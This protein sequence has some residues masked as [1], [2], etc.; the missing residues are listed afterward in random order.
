MSTVTVVG[1]PGSRRVVGFAGAA[2][3]YGIDV[4]VLA[5]TAVADGRLPDRLG[6][7]RVDSPGQDPVA[8]RALRRRGGGGRPLEVGELGESSQWYAGLLAAVRE[9]QRVPGAVLDTSAAD[10]AVA[11]DKRLTRQRLVA[12]GVPV[13]GEGP[14]LTEP[15]QVPD[16]LSRPGR[17]FVKPVHGSS[18]AGVLALTVGPGVQA[19]T[20]CRVQDDRLVNELA[21][22]RLNDPAAIQDLLTRLLATG[23]VLVE[24][25]FPKAGL[26]ERV[27]DLRVV[28]VAGQAR[29]CVVRTSRGP[30]TN[31]HLG[32]RRG[33][34]AAVRAHASAALWDIVIQ[35]CEAAAATFPETWCVG[36]DL[37]IDSR[38]SRVAV[39]EVNAFGDLLPGVTWQGED[40]YASQARCLAGRLGVA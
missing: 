40:S 20:H 37:M 19:L 35:T 10:L 2:A 24:R 1:E 23:P 8:D 32:N 21:A 5:W 25:W 31:L 16:L 6:L 3:A 36:V 7:V 33:D 29:Q 28:V 15:G 4:E 34:L 12:A 30:I 14:V 22:Q 39:A 9:L 26:G 13:P 18:G 27:F 38:W 17:W 11:F